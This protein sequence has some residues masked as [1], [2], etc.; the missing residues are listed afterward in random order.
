M[1]DVDLRHH[2]DREVTSDLLDFAVNVRLSTPPRWLR[3]RLVAGLDD[4][5]AY[6]DPA[7]ATAA[8]ARRHHRDPS[9]VLLTSGAAEAFVLLARALRPSQAVVVH[10]Q[11]TEPEAALRAAGH[12]VATGA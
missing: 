12:T 7:S 6:P 11:F 4:L 10:P 1:S 8:V 2:G 3:D 5:A 9:D